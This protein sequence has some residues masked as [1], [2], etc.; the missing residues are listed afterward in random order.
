MAD[1]LS[2]SDKLCNFCEEAIPLSLESWWRVMQ[3][4]PFP[5]E[6]CVGAKSHTSVMPASCDPVDG[7][8]CFTEILLDPSNTHRVNPDSPSPA[9]RSGV[10]G[11]G[12]GG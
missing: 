4:S 1:E 6:A 10:G 12:S 3:S 5:G 2:Y 11:Q 9:Y 8:F 7:G